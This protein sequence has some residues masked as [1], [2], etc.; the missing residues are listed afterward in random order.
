ME[1][2]DNAINEDRLVLVDFYATWCQPCQMQHPV[3]AELKAQL[4]DRLRIL[5]INIDQHTDTAAR[6]QVRSVPT[7]MLFRQGQQL[8][9]QS[10][11]L[12][13]SDLRATLAPFLSQ[14]C[15]RPHPA[16][17]AL[18]PVSLSQPF[19]PLGRRPGL[20]P[21]ARA[22]HHP[23]ACRHL[24]GPAAGPCRHSQR[25][26]ADTHARASRLCGPARHRLLLP[27]LSVSLA[28]HSPRPSAY[29]GR[30]AVCRKRA[31]GLDRTPTTT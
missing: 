25:R 15:L 21:L 14:P 19:S 10:G 24:C 13:L 7:L 5:K 30:T 6:F 12:S 8:W 22:G 3:L 17:R 20:H 31:D 16:V 4:G 23:P 27:W 28:P 2:F 1:T 29:P 11:Y 18:G 9:R 26:T